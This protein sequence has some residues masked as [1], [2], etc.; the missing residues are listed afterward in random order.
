[1]GAFLILITGATGFIGRALVARLQAEDL[2]IRVLVAARGRAEA[3]FAPPIEVVKGSLTEPERLYRAMLGVHTVYHLVGAQWWG[4]QRD[5]ERVDVAGTQAVITA[6]RAAR[7]GRLI[8]LSHLGAAPSSAFTLLRAKGR[9]EEAVRSS[10]LPYTIF[11]TGIV[12]GPGDTF[13]NGIAQLIRGNPFVFFQPGRGE[14]LLHP[15]Y[16]DDLTE[17]LYRTLEQ[18]DTVDQTINI[19]GPEYLTFN[20][21]IR[22]V[23]RV[24][25]A[26]RAIFAVPPYL[27]RATSNLMLR[28]FPNWPMTPQWLDLLAANRTA[29]MGT[30]YDLFGI[31]PR[32]FEDTIL[33]Y[34]PKRKYGRELAQNMLRRRRG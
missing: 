12:F 21:I 28:F 2:P 34:M 23:M 33:T 27:L 9:V 30:L 10:G 31:H 3:P 19:G 29:S 11:R 26:R 7:I 18:I 22:T 20:E 16:I 14:G 24:T 17:A 32:R 4:R 25:K 13:V 8:V 5:L 6:G 1:M 15:L